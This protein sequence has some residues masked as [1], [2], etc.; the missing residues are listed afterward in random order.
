LRHH[1]FMRHRDVEFD[2]VAYRAKHTTG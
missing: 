1:H 2:A